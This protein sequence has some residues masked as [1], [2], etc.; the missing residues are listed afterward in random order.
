MKSTT[1][2]IKITS[3]KLN[4]VADMV[5]NKNVVEASALLRFIPKK[6]AALIKKSLDSAMANAE[7]NLKQSK[8]NLYIHTIYATE[9]PKLKRFIPVSRGRSHP[10]L[11]KMSHLKI[12]LKAREKIAPAAKKE[13][14]T[15]KEI[16]A[17]KEAPTAE[18]K[19]TEKIAE[20]AGAKSK[21][22]HS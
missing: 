18:I 11:K 7:N 19:K 4:L 15:K 1:R 6:A 16:P 3:K 9:G 13:T 22:S 17:K 12:E 10:I 8:E 14:Q 21:K 2:Y 5:R 20:T